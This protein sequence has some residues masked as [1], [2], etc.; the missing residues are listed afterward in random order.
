MPRLYDLFS[1]QKGM[2]PYISG[3]KISDIIEAR[4]NDIFGKLSDDIHFAYFRDGILYLETA[5]YAWVNE[6]EFFK[7]TILEKIAAYTRR[8]HA[9]KDLKIKYSADTAPK[10]D[11]KNSKPEN[12]MK[13]M[14]LEQRI[15]FENERKRKMGWTLC[16]TCGEIYTPD[17]LCTFCR[18]QSEIL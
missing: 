12:P 5:N 6:I 4:F 18:C 7:S 1:S 13:N 2:K 8:K 16:T 11:K 17:N 3:K 14:T 9:V 15:H 10:E